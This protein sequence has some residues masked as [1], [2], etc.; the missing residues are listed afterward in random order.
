MSIPEGATHKLNGTFFTYVGQNFS[1]KQAGRIQ[2]KAWDGIEWQDSF[3]SEEAELI[4][5]KAECDVKKVID[6]QMI[7]IDWSKQPTPEYVWVEELSTSTNMV[8]SSGFYMAKKDGSGYE[9]ESKFISINGINNGF[10]RVYHN[11]ESNIVKEMGYDTVDP[12][13][14]PKV[15]EWCNIRIADNLRKVRFHGECDGLGYYVFYTSSGDYKELKPN[16]FIPIK[17]DKEVF[18]EKA[19][20]IM[21]AA[22]DDTQEG[23][24]R[25]MYA[26]GARFTDE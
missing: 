8:C 20:A 26:N 18:I 2:V 10:Y 6:K 9:H 1:D 4:E 16:E 5:I 19:V 14:M 7:D 23:W 22:I 13:Y 3:L 24:A 15:G 25:A 11:P 17:L 12:K 21:N